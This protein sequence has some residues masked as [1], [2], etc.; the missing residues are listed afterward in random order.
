MNQIH[1]RLFI[2]LYITLI[3]SVRSAEF[4]NLDFESANLPV[5]PLGEYGTWQPV[6]L[7][8]PGWT[9]LTGEDSFDYVLHNNATLGTAAVWINGPH[10]T[11]RILE[12]DYT[13]VL[14]P[15]AHPSTGESVDVSIEQHGHVP[16]EAISLQ[17]LASSRPVVPSTAQRFGIYI[18][19]LEVSTYTLGSNSIYSTYGVDIS[20]FRG[21]EIDLRITS[22]RL[23]NEPNGLRLDA[24][25]FSPVAVPEPSTWAL[26]GLGALALGCRIFRRRRVG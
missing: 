21:Q 10:T 25:T 1:Q 18:N 9:I 5:I 8:M 23:P 24:L 26:L 22:F 20:T 6:N 4:T 11:A 17:F 15:G 3:S 14:A 13:V 7:A 16:A 19:G 12:G 2:A